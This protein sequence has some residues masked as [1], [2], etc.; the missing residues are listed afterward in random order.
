MV[1]ENCDLKQ[2]YKLVF[3]D[4]RFLIP[5]ITAPDWSFPVGRVLSSE[6]EGFG[7]DMK[8]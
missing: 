8:L 6:R 5:K 1:P 3:L 4:L 7:E 2:G